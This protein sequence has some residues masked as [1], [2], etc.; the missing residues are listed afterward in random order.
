MGSL[1]SNLFSNWCFTNNNPWLD[2]ARIVVAW[3]PSLFTVNISLC[4][5]QVIHCV[6]HPR[7]KQDRFEVTF[8][9]GFNE[10]KKRAQL[11]MDLEEISMQIQGPWIVMGDFNDILFS[12]ERVGKGST[13]SPT[14]DFRDCVE[15]CNLE[16]L[17]YSG[18]FYTWNN[19]QK[20]EDRVFSKLDRALVNP[21]WTDCFQY[22]EANF[23]PEGCFDHNPILVSLYQDV[24][25]GRKPF[26]YFR[27]W[28][29]ADDFDE[30]IAKSWQE[31]VEGTEMYKLTVKLKRLK[32]ILKCI[33]KEGFHEIHKAEMIAKEELVVL[34]EAVNKD[35]QN[36]RLQNE[37]QVARDKYAKVYKAY[38][39]FLAQKAKVSWAKNGDENTAIF[40]ASLRARR[41]HN[42]IFSIEDA[43]GVWCDTPLTV[44]EAFLQYYHHLLGSE[45]QNRHRVKNC[46]INLGPKVSEVHS[47]R[48]ETE[49][50]TQE[51]KEAIFSIPGLKAP[52]PD[53]FGSCFYQDNWELVGSDVV[54]AVLSFLRSGKILKA[55]NT[56]T[57]TLIPKSSCPR[58]VSDFRSISCCNVIYKAASKVICVRLRQILPD[59]IA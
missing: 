51:I 17:K 31:G 8:V 11:W 57:I 29:D 40:H 37:E 44:Q 58:S 10:D 23:L 15:K 52:G 14:Q 2:K 21:Q 39:L 9:Y 28:K 12:N 46:I 50:T 56:T 38:S 49:Y 1:Y 32:K 19:K 13:K 34:Q 53:G 5:A 24:I 4:T 54:S 22:S 18:I 42:I 26:R 3:L 45:M 36:S 43:Q 33:N 6:V 16:D 27:M 59:L 35:P 25:S 55:I 41:I 30:R 7:Q 47:S 48:L 20:P